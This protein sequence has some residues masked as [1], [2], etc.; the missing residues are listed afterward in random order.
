M[1]KNVLLLLATI[2]FAISACNNSGETPQDAMSDDGT[3]TI[4][5][6]DEQVMVLIERITEIDCEM[7]I[8]TSSAVSDGSNGQEYEQISALRDEKFAIVEQIFAMSSDSTFL[9]GVQQQLNTL[10][11]DAGYCPGLADVPLKQHDASADRTALNMTADARRVAD[12]SCRLMKLHQ[13]MD[14]GSGTSQD[15]KELEAVQA[16]KRLL[17]KQLT[18]LYGHAI[19]LDH[20]FRSKVTEEQESLCNYVAALKAAGR[21]P[22]PF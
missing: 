7:R 1:R 8:L 13:K 11:G 14:G 15:Q 20:S 4:E 6:T 18:L 19:L 21:T 5:A 16:E 12:L 17:I 2:A 10:R 9:N 3:M 22:Q